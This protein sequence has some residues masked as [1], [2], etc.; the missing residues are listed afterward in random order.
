MTHISTAGSH[1]SLQQVPMSCYS[2]FPRVITAGSHESL[3][4]NSCWILGGA[5]ACESLWVITHQ[6]STSVIIGGWRLE[7]VQH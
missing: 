6:S 3:Q 4:L 5:Q 2:R 7:H 1:E